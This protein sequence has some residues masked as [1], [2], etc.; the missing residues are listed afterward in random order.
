[1]D[2]TWEEY[3]MVTYFVLSPFL[4]LSA[5]SAFLFAIKESNVL[6]VSFNESVIVDVVVERVLRGIGV[7]VESGEV[8]SLIIE[9]VSNE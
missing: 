6:I 8:I 5:S 1:M 7:V 4:S 3:L 2:S 9:W